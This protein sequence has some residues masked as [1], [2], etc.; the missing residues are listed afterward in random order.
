M[1][2]MA[3]ELEAPKAGSRA[4]RDRRLPAYQGMRVGRAHA[5]PERRRAFLEAAAKRGPMTDWLFAPAAAQDQDAQAVLES[6]REDRVGT[7]ARF[8]E[9][10]TD[11]GVVE[12]WPRAFG[13]HHAM[14]KYAYLAGMLGATLHYEFDFLENG[15]YSAD[16]AIDLYACVRP[17][18]GAPPFKGNAGAGSALV[19][20]VGGRGRLTLQAMTFAMRDMRDGA[21]REEFVETMCRERGRYG[22]RMLGW[23]FDRVFEACAEADGGDGQAARQGRAAPPCAPGLPR[24]R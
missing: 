4:R 16:L 19:R 14:Q 22:R 17:G 3:V 1:A 11:N 9:Y 13:E 21:G 18:S 2:A 5:E 7:L 15:A 24:R 20:M 12:G 23:A 8:V 6:V 10:L